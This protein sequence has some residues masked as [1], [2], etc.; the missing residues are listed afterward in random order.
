VSRQAAASID[1]SFSCDIEYTCTSKGSP[2]QGP[3]FACGGQPA[4]P[5]EFNIKVLFRGHDITKMLTESHLEE[6]QQVVA[7]DYSENEDQ[8]YD[9]GGDAE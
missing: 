4:E 1:L 9:D 3:T 8:E 6:V 5:P 2:E 7:D